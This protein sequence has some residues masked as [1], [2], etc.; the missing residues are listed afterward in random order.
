MAAES[1]KQTVSVGPYCA[2]FRRQ[3]FA[4]Q[5]ERLSTSRKYSHLSLS[6]LNASVNRFCCCHL[7]G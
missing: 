1:A 5:I 6:I 3:K 2:Y 7:I 4:L